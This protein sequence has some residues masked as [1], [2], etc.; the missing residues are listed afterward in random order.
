MNA[1]PHQALLLEL[2]E[3]R[4]LLEGPLTCAERAELAHQAGLGA[5][6]LAR[7][8]GA[9]IL[10]ARA[11]A[12]RAIEEQNRNPRGPAERLRAATQRPHDQRSRATPTRD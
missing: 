9:M 11:V 10:R 4:L 12:S 2:G 7:L 3:Y 5:S 6:M 1:E 8:V